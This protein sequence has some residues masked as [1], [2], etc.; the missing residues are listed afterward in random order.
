MDALFPQE[1]DMKQ[2]HMMIIVAALAALFGTGIAA[3]TDGKAVYAKTCSACH[4]KGLV[5]APKLGD[6]SMWEPRI[7]KGGVD[8]LTASVIAGKGV[9]APRA[10]AA[11]LS[12]AD[13]K[14]AV[15]YMISQVNCRARDVD[16]VLVRRRL[17]N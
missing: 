9:M 11:S 13:T 4:T 16:P 6:K 1:T 5:G 14:A 10:G 15:E 17:P 8:V 2:K 3:A 7:K 12:D